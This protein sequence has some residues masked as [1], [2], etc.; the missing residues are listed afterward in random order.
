MKSLNTIQVLSKIG[1]IL[2]KI[3]FVCS[4]IGFCGCLIGIISLKLGADLL[5]MYGESL[6][7]ILQRESELTEST[8]YATMIVGMILLAG[9]AVVAKFSEHYFKRELEDGTPFNLAGAK[10]MFILG[11]LIICIP[12][13]TQFIAEI[14]YAILRELLSD[15]QSLELGG[16]AS[17]GIGS[18]FILTSLI[19]RYGAEVIDN[20]EVKDTDKE[21]TE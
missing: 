8:L 13:G 11:I 10:E 15:V 3:M 2:S 19:C 21:I 6:N 9:E 17:V 14:I 1:K 18:M 5:K 16:Y 4:I 7:D 20:K 12:L